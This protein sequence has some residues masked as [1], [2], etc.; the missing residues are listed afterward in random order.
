MDMILALLVVGV[1][2]IVAIIITYVITKRILSLEVN[3]LEARNEILETQHVEVGQ[4][5]SELMKLKEQADERLFNLDKYLAV[6]ISEKELKYQEIA[7]LEQ[8][9][10]YDRTCKEQLQLRIQEAE[11]MQIKTEIELSAAKRIIEEYGNKSK[12]G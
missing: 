10:D 1:I 11:K 3:E 12:V 5:L 6:A 8:Q 7:R 4:Q 9:I 2:G